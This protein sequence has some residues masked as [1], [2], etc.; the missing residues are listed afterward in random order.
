MTTERL[1]CS[2]VWTVDAAVFNLAIQSIL[3]R[4]IFLYTLSTKLFNAF[5]QVIVSN[6][7]FKLIKQSNIDISHERESNILC[8]CIAVLNITA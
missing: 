4:P 6:M 8:E 2:L 7:N 5:F 3:Y 1:N